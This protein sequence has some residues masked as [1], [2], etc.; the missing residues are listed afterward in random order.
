MAC[1]FS[2]LIETRTGYDTL[3]GKDA[4]CWKSYSV[5]V[6]SDLLASRVVGNTT[7]AIEGLSE[8]SLSNAS[9]VVQVSL[10]SACPTGTFL[11]ISPPKDLRKPEPLTRTEY[12][13]TIQGQ[14]DLTG[15]EGSQIASD[16][17]RIRL[18]IEVLAC[19]VSLSF[20]SPFVLEE[21]EL[22]LAGTSLSQIGGDRNGVTHVDMGSLVIEMEASPSNI[23]TLDVGIPTI[24]N[25]DGIYNIIG[26]VRFFTGSTVSTPENRYDIANALETGEHDYVTYLD[27]PQ[28]SEVGTAAYVVVYLLIGISAAI[29]AV[30]IGFTVKYYNTQVMQ[31][32][33]APFLLLY[34]IAALMAILCCI[35]FEPK[36]D[37]YCNW[38]L[39]LILLPVHLHQA[40]TLG[41]LY[42][43]H[44]VVSPL[45]STHFRR[46]EKRMFFLRLQMAMLSFC[47][48]GRCKRKD[49][50]HQIRRTVRPRQVVLIIV[51]WTSPQIILQIVR[52]ATA[53]FELRIQYLSDYSVGRP[54]CSAENFMTGGEAS[55][56]NVMTLASFLWLGVQGLTVL[57]MA[58]V[59]RGLPSIL[60]ES[61][62]LYSTTV[63]SF[64]A[65]AVIFTAVA[66]TATPDSSPGLRFILLVCLI[67]ILVM[68][69]TVKIV[70]PKLVLARSG[71]R[72][73]IHNMISEHNHPSQQLRTR[74]I[75][76]DSNCHITD[77]SFMRPTSSPSAITNLNRRTPDFN[78]T[79]T[80]GVVS[81]EVDIN[82]A[83]RREEG[84]QTIPEDVALSSIVDMER[85]EEDSCEKAP[86]PNSEDIGQGDVLLIRRRQP[87]PN[88]LL[89]S[90]MDLQ[91]KL[92]RITKRIGYGVA[93]SV[94]D[95]K[96]VGVLSAKLESTL[97]RV[98]YESEYVSSDDE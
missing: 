81:D 11:K 28:V 66:L 50:D 27:P 3:F 41:R 52:L 75:P 18:K 94:E 77:T 63:V 69:P 15:M 7:F 72:V 91:H 85:N 39:P 60:N 35:L 22:A 21:S 43:I 17:G 44:T 19:S 97:S 67:V 93:V 9:E 25:E 47:L 48:H 57:G 42:R 24:V 32:C 14:I 13:Y 6:A 84:P 45:L 79:L 78:A 86:Q 38:S 65:T 59:S 5:E 30:M 64:V 10:L 89:G 4:I 80:H 83:P 20:C 58:Y 98:Q 26:I 70:G 51:A 1:G 88:E 74:P 40:I 82:K 2:G 90:M 55:P 33:Q 96:S 53:P 23:Y 29:L 87:P 95:W 34:Q 46:I 8:S 31:I 71:M 92:D 76:G 37:V 54:T 68:V 61:R 16:S 73:L 12:N 36:N 49:D 62:A 56:Q